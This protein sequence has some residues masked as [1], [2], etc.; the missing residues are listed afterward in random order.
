MPTLERARRVRDGMGRNYVICW[1][2]QY[3]CYRVLPM[4][5]DRIGYIYPK[6]E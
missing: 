1:D 2:N 6:I 3:K 4:S 5:D